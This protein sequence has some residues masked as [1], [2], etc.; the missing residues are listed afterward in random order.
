MS[1]VWMSMY[2]SVDILMKHPIFS[3]RVASWLGVGDFDMKVKLN[4]S[5]IAACYDF[6][7]SL[8]SPKPI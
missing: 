8:K 1:L 7:F 2:T 5:S 6:K 3:F 4:G